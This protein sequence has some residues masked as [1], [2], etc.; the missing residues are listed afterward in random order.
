MHQRICKCTREN[1]KKYEIDMEQHFSIINPRILL[2]FE[3]RKNRREEFSMNI[4]FL[5]YVKIVTVA[6]Y[7]FYVNTTIL[8]KSR[9]EYSLLLTFMNRN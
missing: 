6:F 3:N 7:H 9:K 2:S 4:K 5:F 1:H 8:Q